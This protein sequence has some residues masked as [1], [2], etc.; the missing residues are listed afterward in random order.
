MARPG[1]RE[2]IADIG[3]RGIVVSVTEEIVNAA[4]H[5]VAYKMSLVR[6]AS[7]GLWAAG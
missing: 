4:Q 5:N 7:V 6:R 1:R 2:V 3:E